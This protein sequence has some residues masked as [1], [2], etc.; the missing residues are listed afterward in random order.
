MVCIHGVGYKCQA[1]LSLPYVSILPTVQFVVRE[2][3]SWHKMQSLQAS[4]LRKPLCVLVPPH[5][6][7]QK[8]F[9]PLVVEGIS[10]PTEFIFVSYHRIKYFSGPESRF[11][12]SW[13]TAVDFIGATRFSTDQGN[14]NHFQTGLPPRMLWE[15]DIAPFIGDLT[16]VQNKVVVLLS[17]LHKTND[18]MGM[19]FSQHTIFTV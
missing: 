5:T 14:T 15:G 10:K 3:C 1:T 8:L 18:M 13:R 7:D 9:C 17:V 6:F 12:E 19:S 2:R 16:A 11:G 4:L